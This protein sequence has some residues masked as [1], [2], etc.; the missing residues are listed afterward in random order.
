MNMVNGVIKSNQNFS[1][2]VD[3]RRKM[4][5]SIKNSPEKGQ[6]ESLLLE[7]S[8]SFDMSLSRSLH[9]VEDQSAKQISESMEFNFSIS[10]DFTGKLV[11]E[12]YKEGE[13][14]KEDDDPWSPENTASRIAD[15]VKQAFRMV[16]NEDRERFENKDEIEKFGNIQKDAV[17]LGF[18]QARG[19]LGDLEDSISKGIGSTFDLVM[20]ELDKFFEDPDAK[21]E[22]KEETAPVENNP[23]RGSFYSSQSFSLSFQ[24]EVNAQGNFNPDELQAFV[25]DSFGQVQDMFKEFIGS[26]GEEGFNPMSLFSMDS[27]NND[28]ISHLLSE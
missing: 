27:L 25:D 18:K 17:K 14:V 7:D 1:L 9:V 23:A 13:V 28:K 5:E 15:F 24:L 2:S 26:D 11:A 20:E 12:P 16:R 3:S 19:I 8:F 6:I 4:Q 21:P 10:M 22:P